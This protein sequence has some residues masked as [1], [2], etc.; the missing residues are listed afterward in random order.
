MSGTT[1][2]KNIRIQKEDF[3]LKQEMEKIT[4]LSKNIGAVVA[5]TGLCRDN[6]GSLAAL[7]I[8]HYPGMAEAQIARIAETAGKRWPLCA[9]TVIHRYGYIR[10]GEQI[11]LV[12]AASAHR[13]AA[14]E[15]A[16]FMMD[17]LKTD[18]PFWKKEHLDDQKASG[19]IEAQ[20]RD[21]TSRNRW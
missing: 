8:E 5:F 18:I 19:W 14:F 17:F 21:S 7:E 9:L 20:E 6:E 15:A 1:L 2:Q 11:V 3:D 13:K 4:A 12:I 10:A 16:D